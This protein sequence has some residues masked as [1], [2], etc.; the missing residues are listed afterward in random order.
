MTGCGF[1]HG[2]RGGSGRGKPDPGWKLYWWFVVIAFCICAAANI[3]R[4]Q[5]FLT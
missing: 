4:E 5:G 3:L 2:G 1:N